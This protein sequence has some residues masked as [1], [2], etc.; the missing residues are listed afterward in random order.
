M[1]RHQYF[2]QP[3]IYAATPGEKKALFSRSIFIYSSIFI[4]LLVLAWFVWFSSYF[5]I[6]TIIIS[7]S[8]NPEVAKEID[9]F[10]GKNILFF[11][12]GKIEKQLASGQTS[13]SSLEIYKGLP[14]E[15]KIKV[16]VREPKIIWQTKDRSYFIDG[17]GVVF[18]LNNSTISDEEKLEL[19]IIIDNKNVGVNLGTP[20]VTPDFVQYTLDLDKNFEGKIGTK[21][22]EFRVNETTLQIEVVTEAGWRVLLDTSRDFNSQL[23][24]LK[25]IFDQYGGDIKEYVDLRVEGRA[26]Y[27]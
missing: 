15:L 1:N 13:I 6:K 10:K 23:T 4:L 17:N 8:L 9:K 26:Y 5:K 22:K 18:E 21:I 20:I 27:K 7:G 16:N 2:R 25:K 24:V 14:N 12:I 11:Q 19:P 3:K